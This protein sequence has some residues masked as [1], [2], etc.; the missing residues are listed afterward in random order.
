MG[1]YMNLSFP[2]GKEFLKID[3][4]DERLKG[5]IVSNLHHYTTKNTPEVLVAR[6]LEKEV[7]RE[8]KI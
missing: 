8:P 3:I 6:A 2:Y 5:V 7:K 4:P 1:V